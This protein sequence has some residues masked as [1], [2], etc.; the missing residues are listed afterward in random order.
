MDRLAYQNMTSRNR[1]LDRL[2]QPTGELTSKSKVN[3]QVNTYQL[4]R[5]SKNAPEYNGFI[6]ALNN[7]IIEDQHRTEDNNLRYR[8]EQ[9]IDDN[10]QRVYHPTLMTESERNF[11]SADRCGLGTRDHQ[12]N[13]IAKNKNTMPK[14][15]YPQGFSQIEHV[16]TDLTSQID[17]Q[18]GGLT[19]HDMEQQI[20]N[21]NKN[22]Q[23]SEQT[24]PP[25]SQLYPSQPRSPY[26]PQV[27]H[28]NQQLYQYSQQLPPQ[29]LLDCSRMV[30]FQRPISSNMRP[31][32]CPP[33]VSVLPLPNPPQPV[34]LGHHDRKQKHK[35][36]Q[37]K[38]PLNK[39]IK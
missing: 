16:N 19:N 30:D 12:L 22:M 33:Q 6:S 21:L 36:I 20:A 18:F 8:A 31:P 15:N 9:P 27:D 10:L 23:T 29:H 37:S 26:N 25:L 32:V 39:K 17:Y 28:V 11:D 38:V 34:I 24:A 3:T 14:L 5:Q 13:A 4:E 2:A 1:A 35:H 7:N